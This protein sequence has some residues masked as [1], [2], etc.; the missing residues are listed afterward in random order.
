MNKS[1]KFSLGLSFLLIFLVGLFLGIGL[2]QE[3]R[4]TNSISET[5]EVPASKIWNYLLSIEEMPSRRKDVVRVEIIE[6]DLNHIPL[7][8][9]EITDMGGYMLFKRGATIPDQKL[10]V[11][12]YES[13]F[14]MRGTW[15]YEMAEKNGLTTVTITEESEIF[16]PLIRGAYFL[17][18]RDS[19]LLQEMS[20]LR[21]HFKDRN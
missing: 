2:F 15:T 11:I 5:M 4:Y 10:E 17:A 7:A 9:K 21:N 8:W 14:K 16:S 1:L 18:G 12:L 6:K 3:A 20:M 19:T 13:S